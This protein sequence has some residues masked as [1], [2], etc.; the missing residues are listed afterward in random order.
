MKKELFLFVAFLFVCLAISSQEPV[1]NFNLNGKVKDV[2]V[3]QLQLIYVDNGTE[4]QKTVNI[5]D[6]EFSVSGDIVEPT[7]ARLEIGEV[8]SAYFWLESG[9]IYPFLLLNRIN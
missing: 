3:K 7:F 1:F 9:Y 4:I 2:N 5:E 8:S 6:G